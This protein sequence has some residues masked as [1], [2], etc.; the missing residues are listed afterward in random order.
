[1]SSKK[2]KGTATRQK[3]SGPQGT[4]KSQAMAAQ[5]IATQEVKRAA[6]LERQAEARA[7]AERRKR[8]AKLRMIGIIA[9]VTVVLLAIIAAAIINEISKPGQGV[10]QQISNHIQSVNDPH[11]YT[12]DPPTSGPHLS[13]LAPW[14]V[15]STPI[16][17]ELSLHNLEDGGVIISYRPDLA[18]E[19]VNSL[20]TIARSY[21]NYVLMA[22]YPGLSDPIVLT[23]WTRIDRM[24]TV[25]EARIKRF[26]DAYRGKDQHQKS[27]S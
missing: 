20:D 4:N 18:K 6:R 22:P 2:S 14:G 23:A 10:Q 7:A 27:G 16:T 19:M 24:S 5:L 15:S 26:I 8:I 21:D 1:M 11:S 12:T 17:K 9:G 13:G 25:D 3:P